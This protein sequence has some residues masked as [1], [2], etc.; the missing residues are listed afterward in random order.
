MACKHN[1]A[2]IVERIYQHGYR[3]TTIRVCFY[4]LPDRLMVNFES[5]EGMFE[6]C[7]ETSTLASDQ[8]P[9]PTSYVLQNNRCS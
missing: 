6:D 2:E 9:L 1:Q 3:P 8:S 4:S 5:V 7:G